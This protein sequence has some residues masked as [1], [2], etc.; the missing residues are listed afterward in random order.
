MYV[1]LVLMSLLLPLSSQ[2]TSIRL[3]FTHPPTHPSIH[4]PIHTPTHAIIYYIQNYMGE[5]QVLCIF[6]LYSDQTQNII[7]TINFV[8]VF[9][10]CLFVIVDV[11][12][13]TLSSLYKE[14]ETSTNNNYYKDNT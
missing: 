13:V 6:I 2:L 8:N 11:C 12:G 5:I 14:R 7:H 9:F 4:S 3:I 1:E 10:V